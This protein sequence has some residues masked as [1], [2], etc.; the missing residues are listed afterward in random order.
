MP[1]PIQPLPVLAEKG[2]PEVYLSA[3]YADMTRLADADARWDS[4]RSRVDG[5]LLHIN[6][7]GH[8]RHAYPPD[9]L[10]ALVRTMDE[11]GIRMAVESEGTT[12]PNPDERRI[13]AVAARHQLDLLEPLR[14]VG[15][16]CHLLTLDGSLIKLLFPGRGRQGLSLEAAVRE[17]VVFLEILRERLPDT[18]IHELVNFPN[19]GWKGEPAY[20]TE[21]GSPMGYGDYAVC[22]EALLAGARDAGVPFD[23]VTVDNPYGYAMGTIPVEPQARVM[24]DTGVIDWMARIRDLE[25]TV[26]RH[27]IAYDLIVNDQE[28]GG[29]SPEAYHHAT[30]AFV[31]AYR[32]VGGRPDRYLVESWYQYPDQ[33]EPEEGAYTLAALGRAVLDRLGR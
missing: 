14:K 11:N 31:D 32:R 16:T 20:R 3:T 25:D 33:V 30:L 13:G 22:L 17:I 19:W 8:P 29:L 10:R 7:V 4:V 23:G 15:G 5:L 24:E 26:R 27:G 2:R 18:R 21:S 28:S 9:R 6:R 1:R 12:W